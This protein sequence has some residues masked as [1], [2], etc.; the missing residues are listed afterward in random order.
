M[1]YA[2]GPLYGPR[3][4]FLGVLVLVVDLTDR[5]RA[6]EHLRLLESVAVYANDGVFITEAGPIDDPG[7]RILFANEA[8]TRMTGYTPS[9]VLGRTPRLLQGP[10]TDRAS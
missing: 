7:P 6:E 4:D 8:F 2:A 10:D 3:G 5:K 9:E 1:K